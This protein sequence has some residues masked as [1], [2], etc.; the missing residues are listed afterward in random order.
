MKLL[1]ISE[2]TVSP[3]KKTDIGK[4]IHEM[5]WSEMHLK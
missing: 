2:D 5:Q 4:N 1:S 3:K